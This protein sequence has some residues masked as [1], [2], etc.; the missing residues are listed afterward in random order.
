MFPISRKLFRICALLAV[1][2]FVLAIYAVAQDTTPKNKPGTSTNDKYS[3]SSTEKGS[4][5][6][7]K[8][9]VNESKNKLVDINSAFPDELAQLPG[10]GNSYAQKI[11]AGRPY[12]QKTDLLRRKIIPAATYKKIENDI[13][14]RQK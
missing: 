10:I 6:P 8:R 4:A 5:E 7:G 14:A 12:R 13:I 9:V 11:I 3:S 1:S 2:F